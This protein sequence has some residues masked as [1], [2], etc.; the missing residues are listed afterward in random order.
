[1]QLRSV[2]L[3]LW[4]TIVSA[5]SAS[6]TEVCNEK[7]TYDASKGSAM[8]QVKIAETP[9]TKSVKAHAEF[10]NTESQR[11]CISQTLSTA[12]QKARA[13]KRA[14][15][16]PCLGAHEGTVCNNLQ[17]GTGGKCALPTDGRMTDC[18]YHGGTC[19]HLMFC[20]IGQYAACAA[21]KPESCA[22]SGTPLEGTCELVT[23][24]GMVSGM[25]KI[26]ECK[27]LHMPE[28][29]PTP[30]PEKPGPV[31]SCTM[32]ANPGDASPNASS[33]GEPTAGNATVRGK[34]ATKA[35]RRFSIAHARLEGK[36]TKI[37]D[38]RHFYGA[39]LMPFHRTET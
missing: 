18:Q 12:N 37:S 34:A 21:G 20:D 28:P 5:M 17:V 14:L 13:M 29:E 16:N 3:A 24:T 39:R 22:I 2:M 26:F 4:L 33:F 31:A 35:A 32:D 6:S 25:Q 36:P 9:S 1:M 19:E 15:D 11:S 7:D 8:L 30:E 38:A 10:L 27:G 23:T